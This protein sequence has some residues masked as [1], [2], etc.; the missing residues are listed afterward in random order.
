MASLTTGYLCLASVE[1]VSALT[2]Y[3]RELP[4]E[5]QKKGRSLSDLGLAEVA[6][7]WKDALMVIDYLAANRVAILGGDVYKCLNGKMES[8]YDNWYLNRERDQSWESFVT[9]S[10]R[11]AWEFIKGYHARNGSS[12]YYSIV[13]SKVTDPFV[14]S[15]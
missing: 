3:Y 13:G 12:F 5:L 1:R 9:A 8:T 6:W 7:L 15:G 14:W 2:G 10:H 11:K 4:Q